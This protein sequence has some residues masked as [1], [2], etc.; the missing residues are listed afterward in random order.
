M[1]VLKFIVDGQILKQDPECD[2]SG[3]IP[4]SEQFLKAS[5]TFSPEWKSCTKVIA[6]FSRLGA[7]YPPCLL[8]DGISCTIPSEAVNAKYFKIQVIGKNKDGL[9]ML[10]NKIEICQNGGG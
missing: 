6:F 1:R 7:E 3:L 5:F 2:F 10:T 9:K 8:K 4:G